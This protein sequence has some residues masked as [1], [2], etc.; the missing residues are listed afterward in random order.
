[1]FSEIAIKWTSIVPES[2]DL[3]EPQPIAEASFN[4]ISMDIKTILYRGKIDKILSSVLTVTET[5]V[6]GDILQEKENEMDSNC[7]RVST[8]TALEKCIGLAVQQILN[9]MS[10]LLGSSFDNI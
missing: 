6:S 9:N 4:S 5:G 8:M 1:M 7:A 10:M 2:G 3:D